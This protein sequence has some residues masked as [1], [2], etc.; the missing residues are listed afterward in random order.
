MNNFTRVLRQYFERVGQH[1][2]GTISIRHNGHSALV[3]PIKGGKKMKLKI[4][5]P[6]GLVVREKSARLWRIS[7]ELLRWKENIS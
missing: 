4:F 6:D 2:S 5:N 7:W 1:P 3:F